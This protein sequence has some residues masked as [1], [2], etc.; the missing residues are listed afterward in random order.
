M[1]NPYEQQQQPDPWAWMQDYSMPPEP[2]TMFSPEAGGDTGGGQAA[3]PAPVEAPPQGYSPYI[4]ASTP[5]VLH[6]DVGAPNP[7]A[8]QTQQSGGALEGVQTIAEGRSTTQ[9][10]ADRYVQEALAA[11][12]PQ[13]YITEFLQRDPGDYHRIQ[14]AYFSGGPRSDPRSYNTLDDDVLGTGN[15]PSNRDGGAAITSQQLAELLA[16]FQSING[17]DDDGLPGDDPGD[18]P[19]LTVPGENLS[20][21]IDEAILNI[22][23][24]TSPLDN[25]LLDYFAENLFG[26][27]RTSQL[28]TRLNAIREESAR[29]QRGMLGD[30]EAALASS[31]Q[32]RGGGQLTNSLGRIENQLAETFAPQIMN[33]FADTYEHEDQMELG[34]LA[35]ATGFSEQQASQLLA[36]VAAG[37][38]RQAMLAD[39]ALKQLDQNITWNKFLAEFGLEREKVMAEIQ[40]G[41]LENILPI[42]TLFINLVGQSRGGYV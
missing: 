1:Y 13:S 30:V 31:G 40:A 22:L 7:Y 41:R 4:P 19:V 34:L 10:Q 20:P 33:A 38:Q 18:F 28:D 37:N 39:I 14:S 21:A 2:A 16:L 15:R 24:Q 6:A 11:G 35:Q 29:Q 3:P 8:V 9:S 27:R 42:L 17:G 32:L 26:D 25:E 36:G 23:D 5:E 12:I